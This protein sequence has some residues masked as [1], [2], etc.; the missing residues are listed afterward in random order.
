M[1]TIITAKIALAACVLILM[2]HLYTQTLNQKQINRRRILQEIILNQTICMH[3]NPYIP[4]LL[5]VTYPFCTKMENDHN[6]E[7]DNINNH[8]EEQFVELEIDRQESS[9]KTLNCSAHWLYL[10]PFILFSLIPLLYSTLDVIPSPP[11]NLTTQ[12]FHFDSISFF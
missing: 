12:G 2:R 10:L 4:S 6:I 7:R 8:N 11:Y 1:D 9:K 5:S 3:L